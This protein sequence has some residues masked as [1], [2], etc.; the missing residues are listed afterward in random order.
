V[1]AASVG[2]VLRLRT[3]TDDRAWDDFVTGHPE[4]T[5]FHLSRF[6]RTAAPLLG[7]RAHLAVAEADGEVVGVVPMLL[8]SVGPSL[9]VNYWPRFPYLGP[10]LRPG[11]SAEVV[12][13]AAVRHLRP[14]PVLHVG[15]R[16][17][18]PFPVPDRSGWTRDNYNSAIVQIGG[19]DDDALLALLTRTQ[20]N[21]VRRAVQHGLVT[22]PATRLEISLHLGSW[23]NGALARQGLPPRWPAGSHEKLYDALAPSG[24]CVATAVRRDDT[25]LAVS[26]DMRLGRRLIGWELGVAEEGR[27]VGASPLLITAVMRRAR[28]L[29][30]AEFDMLGAPTPGIAQH[31]RSLGAEICPSGAAHWSPAWLPSRRFVRRLSGLLPTTRPA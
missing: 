21:T 17:T 8:R 28:D 24:V 7:Q 10:L 13:A 18:T 11:F 12:L 16:S 26:L 19:R 2:Q 27:A 22:G 20:R 25:P 31:K 23:A 5:A 30:A 9:L 29:G 6:L 1:I 15:L 14:R 4:G 3:S